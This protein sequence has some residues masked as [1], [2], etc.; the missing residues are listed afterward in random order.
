MTS[1]VQGT[2]GGPDAEVVFRR[3]GA[4]GHILLNRP[5]ALNALTHDMVRAIHAALDDWAVD[6]AV[7]AIVIEGAGGRAFCAGGDIRV[8]HDH[9]KA[10]RFDEALAFWRDEYELN[11][12]IRRYPKPYVA[13][14]DGIVMG[15]GVG[16]SLHGSHLVA[17]EGFVFAMPE[18]GIGFF[19]D[20]GATY[21]LPRL[22]GLAGRYIAL[23]GSRVGALDAASLGLA[24]TAVASSALA[25]I[26]DA[27]AAGGDPSAVIAAAPPAA[28]A[29]RLGAAERA[30][31]ARCFAGNSIAAILARLDETAAEGSAFAA[32][33]AASMRGKSP[34]SLAIALEQMKRGAGLSF[35]EAMRLEFRIVSQMMRNADFFEGVRAAVID[36]DQAPR[37][38]PSA[39]SAVTPAMVETFFQPLE[40]ELAA[41]GTRRP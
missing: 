36:K 2:A 9:G 8:L 5:R 19:P 39:L 35:E 15:G 41:D 30:V 14:V 10:G 4:V 32:E 38:T 7:R 1:G 24:T 18:V 25:G 21:E 3:L 31:V 27:L 20:V 17:G 37:W 28:G 6:D 33:T 16:V 23:T 26:R 40:R 13:L 11:I 12:R 22:P 34:L 29:A